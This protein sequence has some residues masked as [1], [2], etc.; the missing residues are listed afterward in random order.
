MLVDALQELTMMM[1][2]VLAMT[3]FTAALAMTAC[4]SDGTGKAAVA[5]EARDA[6]AGRE[7]AE[8]PTAPE[9]AE[10]AERPAPVERA[11]PSGHGW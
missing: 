8:R 7:V 3:F 4:K 9:K 5:A 2:T 11:A 1:R 10:P 6:P